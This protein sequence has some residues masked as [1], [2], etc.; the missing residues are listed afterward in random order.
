MLY[1]LA[2]PHCVSATDL[3]NWVIVAKI[4]PD[5]YVKFNNTTK[6]RARDF[7]R[8]ME[9]DVLSVVRRLLMMMKRKIK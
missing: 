6:Y 8:I 3:S 9:L 4:E 1:Y 7:N 2:L 5:V